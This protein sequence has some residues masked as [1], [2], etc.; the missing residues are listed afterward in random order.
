[1]EAENP[2][3]KFRLTHKFA[4]VVLLLIALEI[5]SVTTY[6]AIKHQRS[7]FSQAFKL[8]SLLFSREKKISQPLIWNEDSNTG[9]KSIDYIALEPTKTNIELDAKKGIKSNDVLY[10]GI[11]KADAP[12]G[13]LRGQ[14][15]IYSDDDVDDEY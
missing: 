4:I 6:P 10:T 1:M 7:P 3:F 12:K 8:R 14:N 9:K 13:F 11:N 15:I 2:G 5:L